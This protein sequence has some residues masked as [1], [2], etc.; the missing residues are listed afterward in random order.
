MPPEH[1]GSVEVAEALDRL[2]THAPAGVARLAELSGV[3]AQADA[4]R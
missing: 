3:D 2:R 1:S 4:A